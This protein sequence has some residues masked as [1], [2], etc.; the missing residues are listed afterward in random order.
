MRILQYI[1]IRCPLG[2]VCRGQSPIILRVACSL[3]SV[4]Y[5]PGPTPNVARVADVMSS[6][7]DSSGQPKQ[8][9]RRVCGLRGDHFSTG[10]H[11]AESETV[12][13]TNIEVDWVAV[14]RTPW[15]QL[16]VST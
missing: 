6:S 16:T 2:F 12:R 14:Q 9:P 5:T 3:G 15:M 7:L 11:I 13:L 8:A 10:L 4:S 1:N